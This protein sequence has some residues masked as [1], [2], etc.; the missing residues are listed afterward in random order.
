MLKQPVEVEGGTRR[1]RRIQRQRAAIMQ[2]SAQLFARQGYLA[3]TTKDIA[4]SLDIGESTLYGYFSSKQEILKAI[5]DGQAGMVDS[6]LVHL[7]DLD[8][9]PSMVNMVDLLMEKVLATAVY[10]RVVIAEAWID[11]QVL[12]AFVL[13]RWQPVLERLQDLISGR[14]ASGAFRPIDPRLG[15]RM[16]LTAFIGAILPALRGIEPLPSPEQ[17]RD[18]AETVVEFFGAGLAVRKE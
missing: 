16:I 2:A 6:L 10:T 15:A 17:R 13:A 8:D 1:E 3:T 5:L 14:V 18:L 9:R 11:D 7:N 12:Q 4:H